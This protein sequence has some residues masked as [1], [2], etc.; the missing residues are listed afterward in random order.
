MTSPSAPL[1]TSD[2]VTDYYS[3]LG[4]L[5]RMAWGDNLH[6]GYWEGASDRS[7][8]Q[9][10]TD[11]FTDVLT[12]RL[13]VG[14]GSRVL[15]AGCGI[16][17]PAVRVASST[18]AEVWGV[19][20]SQQQVGQ[21]VELAERV[22]LSGRVRFALRD[23][24]ETG[25]ETESFDAVLAFESIVHMDRPRALREWKRVLKPGGRIVLTDTFPM[26]GA[27]R[28]P[29][30]TVGDVASMATLEDYP[31]LLSDAGLELVELT[32]V[33][34]HTKFTFTRVLDGILRCRK[35]FEREHGMTVEEVLNAMKPA[36][37]QA[38]Q[39]AGFGAP[40]QVG[41]LVAVARKPASAA[42]GAR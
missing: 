38:S 36:H 33:T 42:A 2:Q 25:Y 31:R 3:A 28:R 12:E 19:T 15:D 21:A 37:P 4:P 16:G 41:C 29:G 5:L 9:E 35:D 8:P 30:D 1:P 22:G 7:S 34:E 10:A 11:R 40:P 32:D 18:G 23:A 13:G 20:I 39:A 27:V 17:S 6:F 14:A 24:M 26:D